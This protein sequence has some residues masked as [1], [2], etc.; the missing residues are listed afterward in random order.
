M[1]DARDH[2]AN[3][4]TDAD[5]LRALVLSVMS[6]RD[7]LTAERD[8]LLQRVERQQLL[9][10][11]LNRLQFGQKSER[12]PEDQRQ[13]AFEDLEQ[14]I[15][16]DQAE[17]EKRDPELRQQRA[18]KRRSSRGALPAHLPRIEITL[19]PNDTNC[20][21]CRAAMTMIGEDK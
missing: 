20:P 3:L 18:A 21:C 14:A 4:P 16:Q 12:L 11:K 15:A 17:T 8:D 1:S 2:M 7:A 10:W 9:I 13:M 19:T 6:E 5:A